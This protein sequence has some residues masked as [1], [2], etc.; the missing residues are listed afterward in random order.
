MIRFYLLSDTETQ[1]IK[2]SRS[3]QER[4]LRFAQVGPLNWV[5]VQSQPTFPLITEQFP[6]FWQTG[7]HTAETKTPN[8]H[9]S[10][11]RQAPIVIIFDTNS[12][13][14]MRPLYH[15]VVIWVS[16]SSPTK[17]ICNNYSTTSSPIASVQPQITSLQPKYNMLNRY[18]M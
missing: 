16:Q 12:E 9:Y 11:K 17:K 14:F 13:K 18:T 6:L 3:Y 2:Y 8:Y 5:L 4:Y 1:S 15:C 10:L 7:L